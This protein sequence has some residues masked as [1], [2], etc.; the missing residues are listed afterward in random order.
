MSNAAPAHPTFTVI[1]N[2][3]EFTT[4]EHT[5]TGLQIKQL[6][7][8][9]GD[10]ELFEVKGANSVPVGND[11]EVHIHNKITFRAIPTGTFGLTSDVAR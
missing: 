2:N 6:A 4:H 9:P 5:L 10:Y 11:D 3:A 8:I 7:G 1:V